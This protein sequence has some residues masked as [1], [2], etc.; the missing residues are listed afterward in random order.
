M[1][2]FVQVYCMCIRMYVCVADC[3]SSL[4]SPLRLKSLQAAELTRHRT[5]LSLQQMSVREKEEQVATLQKQC[6]ILKMDL[7][8]SRQEIARCPLCVCVSVVHFVSTVVPVLTLSVH[9]CFV[10]QI[11]GRNF[12]VFGKGEGC[13]AGSGAVGA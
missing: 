7:Q 9:L 4:P 2:A 6:D 8:G 10:R 13:E 12:A 5:E 3:C 1:C 11:Q